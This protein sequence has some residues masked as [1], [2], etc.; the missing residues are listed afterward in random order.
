MGRELY[1]YPWC[2]NMSAVRNEGLYQAKGLWYLSAD[3]DEWFEDVDDILRFF[4]K[5]IYRKCDSATY[6]QRNYFQSFG[7]AYEDN[8]TFRM[9]RITPEM[10]FEGRIHDALVVPTKSV[11]YQLFSYV[12]HYGFV[13][14]NEQQLQEKYIRNTRILLQDVY[15]YPG[16]LRYNFQLANELKCKSYVKEAEAYF[17]RGI[18]LTQEFTRENNYFGK[19]HVVDLLAIYYDMRNPIIFAMTELLQDCFRLTFAERAFL[20]FNRAS[21]ALRFHKPADEIL[22]YYDCY[23]HEKE[24]YQKNPRDSQINSYIGLRACERKEQIIDGYAIA[25]CALVQKGEER[26]AIAKMEQIEPTHMLDQRRNFFEYAVAASDCVY[27]KFIEMFSVQDW[28]QW[29][30]ELLDAFLISICEDEITERQFAR[31]PAFFE[32]F[33]IKTLEWYLE[34]FYVQFVEQMKEKLYIYAMKRKAEECT[35]QE[36][37]FCAYILKMKYLETG[38]QEKDR[39]LFSQY[40]CMTAVYCKNYYHPNILEQQEKGVLSADLYAVYNIYQAMQEN[41][42]THQRIMYLKEALRVFPGFKSEIQYLLEQ[43]TKPKQETAED[44]MARLAGQ[45]K[46]QTKELIRQGKI[47]QA[48]EILQELASYCPNDVEIEEL[49][50]LAKEEIIVRG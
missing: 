30:E 45:L 19:L 13:H 47:N 18:A 39:E 17:F 4:K 7:G 24:C 37:Y 3:D 35:V 27:E 49:L 40:V 15:E 12:H 33:S 29:R 34:Q 36:L 50:V 14:D 23:E 32:K 8:H 6:I 9:V 48:E 46:A 44:E 26:E 20:N 10:H 38:K 16:N 5:G 43:F 2:D 11:N 42:D 41:A 31:L 21:L 1:H 22:H 28:E 25:F